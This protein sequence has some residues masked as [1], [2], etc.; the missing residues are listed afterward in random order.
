MRASR[1]AGHRSTA[2]TLERR[3][4]TPLRGAQAALWWRGGSAASA[5]TA[6]GSTRRVLR[7]ASASGGEAKTTE[8]D[9]QEKGTPR[10][11]TPASALSKSEIPYDLEQSVQQP[12]GAACT[13]TRRA[14]QA[15]AGEASPGVPMLNAT[16][17]APPDGTCSSAAGGEDEVAEAAGP[18]LAGGLKGDLEAGPPREE[19]LHGAPPLHHGVGLLGSRLRARD[20]PQRPGPG[21]VALAAESRGPEERPVPGG[22]FDHQLRLRVHH[23]LVEAAHERVLLCMPGLVQVKDRE[24][25]GRKDHRLPALRVLKAEGEGQV[26]GRREAHLAVPAL[27]ASP[28]LVQ[29]P[30]LPA[31]R[32][33]HEV[34]GAG[35]PGISLSPVAH[36]PVPHILRAGV[37][38]EPAEVAMGHRAPE[39]V[40]VSALDAQLSST[41]TAPPATAVVLR[42]AAV[43]GGA[44]V[45]FTSV[46]GAVVATVGAGVVARA[47]LVGAE[48]VEAAGSNVVGVADAEVAAAVVGGGGV[49]GAA[50]ATF[51]V[52]IGAGVVEAGN[53]EVVAALVGDG[54]RVV[55]RTRVLGVDV[56][57]ADV[58]VV[59]VVAAVVVLVLVLVVVDVVVVVTVVVVVV[60]VVV[61]I[62]VVVVVEVMVVVMVVAVAVAVAAGVVVVAIMVVVMVAAVVVVV[63]VVVVAF[64]VVVVV[65]LAVVVVVTVVAAV[66]VGGE[67]VVA[68][69][70]VVGG[71]VA[72]AAVVVATVVACLVLAAVVCAASHQVLSAPPLAVAPVHAAETHVVGPQA[73][74]LAVAAQRRSSAPSVA[75]PHTAVVLVHIQEALAAGPEA[76]A[77]A[78]LATVT[79]AAG[80]HAAADDALLQHALRLQEQ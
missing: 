48:V 10:Y 65:V 32:C 73:A 34:E 67:D 56:E 8:M 74:A 40:Q 59:A 58:V 7:P 33:E 26:G 19:E 76:A 4:G 23:V 77:R 21:V 15:H 62:M 52:V 61:F 41:A 43:V 12:R 6:R 44:V 80:E 1:P 22:S 54:A 49:G 79:G 5:R 20:R 53:V 2:N 38:P 47:V 11:T 70:V 28:A 14:T 75:G 36:V 24:V 68:C 29:V 16:Q 72:A 57:A 71:R 25:E 46:V 37:R 51:A 13:Q 35:L 64:V 31:R 42:G 18:P 3:R 39:E 45:V 78:R 63:V 69:A 27:T 30:V 55:V 60:L 9:V 50:V 17:Q 66:D